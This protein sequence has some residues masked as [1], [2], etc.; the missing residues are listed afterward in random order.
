MIFKFKQTL[1]QAVAIISMGF[2]FLL[3][4]RAQEPTGKLSG[5]VLD[6]NGQTIIGANVVVKG[7]TKGA[8]TDIDGKYVLTLPAGKYDIQIS[9]LSFETKLFKDTEIKAGQIAVLNTTLAMANK[10]LSE[11]VVEAKANRESAAAIVLEQKNSVVLFDGFSGEQIKRTPDRTTADVLKRVSG[12]TIQDNSF[13]VVRGLPDRYNAVYINSS[14]LPSSEPDRKAFAFDIF[15]AVFLND[16]KVIKT[17]M[18]SLTGEF[19]GG[20]IQVKTKDIPE[21]NFYQLS[22][23]TTFNSITSFQPFLKSPGGKTDWLGVDDG[24]RQLPK[25]LASTEDFKTPGILNNAAKA[26][27]TKLFNNS[28]SA[29]RIESMMPGMNGQ[30]S[31]GHNINLNPKSKREDTRTKNELGSVFALT[32]NRNVAYTDRQRNDYDL[33][34]RIIQ[35]KDDTYNINTMLG[36]IWNLAYIYAKPS[37]FNNRISIKNMYNIN[38]NDQSV[39]RTGQDLQNDFD[40]KAYAFQYTENKLWSSQIS[41]EHYIPQGKIKLEWG[42]GYSNLT[43]L[44]PDYKLVNYK[45]N[46]GDTTMPF[47]M[48]AQTQPSFFDQN[49]RFFSDMRDISYSGYFDFSIPVITGSVRHEIKAG[50]S[51]QTKS[52]EFNA[53]SF[54]YCIQTTLF[55][56][57]ISSWAIDSIFDPRNIS[58]SGYFLKESTT[59]ADSYTSGSDTY[60]GYLQLEHAFFENKLRAIWGARLESFTQRLSSFTPQNED[61]PIII[62]TTKIDI[63]PSINLIW[64]V[65]NKM[66]VRASFSQTVSRPEARELAPFQFFDFSNFLMVQ[67]NQN[68]FRTKINNFDLRYEFYPMAG[69]LISVTGFYKQFNNPIEKTLENVGSFRLMSYRNVASSY[70]VGAEFEYR[71]NIASFYNLFKKQNTESTFM[72][73]FYFV[74]NLAIIRSVVDLTG[75]AGIDE[76]RPMQGQSPFIINAGIQYNDT[77]HDWGFSAMYNISGRRIALVGNT[78]YPSFWE[79]PRNVIDLQLSKTFW[80]KFEIRLNARDILANRIIWYQDTNGNRSFDKDTDNE[81]LNVRMGSQ[82]SIT[83]GL[84]L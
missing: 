46:L 71:F 82:Y 38:S 60:A 55:N 50:F 16:I 51:A 25:G 4:A 2:L 45:R 22:L 8:V 14:P 58:T 66:N 10:N 64:G 75:V 84:K 1:F 36:G 47:R 53:R 56:P 69:Q 24:Y 28:F 41:G 31:M 26:E 35:Y 6:P 70:S 81:M 33:T 7:T 12:A 27:Q 43:R 3:E 78:D 37:G 19:A 65:N 61:I 67:G 73:G 63:L 42:G 80:D 9:S 68:L 20:L 18:P 83:L 62:D 13:V 77:K 57:A 76:K 29:K 5:K 79:T 11:V 34:G 32:Y 74:G 59:K 40:V 44:I 21:K 49:G 17:A 48:Q 52:R 15:P 23:G 72:N 54:G 30:F 39:L